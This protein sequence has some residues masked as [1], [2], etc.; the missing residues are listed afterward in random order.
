MNAEIRAATLAKLQRDVHTLCAHPNRTVGSH[1]HQAAREY[2]QARY[3]ELAML[4]YAEA[5]EIPY[6]SGGLQFTNL[7]AVTP[8]ASDAPPAEPIVLG[9]HYD[10]VPSTPGADDNAAAI[11]ITLE[12]AKRLIAAPAERPVVIA[13][14]DAEEPPFFQSD[15]MGSTNFYHHQR[16][17]PVHAAVI[18][19]LVGHAV[20]I[21]GAENTIFMTGMECDP[22]FEQTVHALPPINGLQ[23]VATL[24]DYVGD[25]SDHHAFR[26]NQVPYL[27]LSCGRWPHYHAPSDT[28]DNLDW[29]KMLATTNL[30]ETIVRDIATRNLQ[31]PWMSYDT[32]NTEITTMKQALANVLHNTGLTLKTRTDID[33]IASLLL[34]QELL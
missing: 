12:V 26:M 22:A 3:A 13:H 18:L 28:P 29:V 19:D 30:I 5:F 17:G 11:A 9:A 10:T 15:A 7:A 4:P 6:S 21:H 23:L 34:N 32:T 31:G 33:R 14:F 1:G 24:N 16:T 27:F 25:M 8:G 20:P 2:L